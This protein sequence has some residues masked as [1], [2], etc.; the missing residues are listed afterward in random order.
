MKTE[1]LFLSQHGVRTSFVVYKDLLV[2]ILFLFLIFGHNH[3]HDQHRLLIREKL[4]LN[5]DHHLIWRVTLD[6]P[7]IYQRSYDSRH[8]SDEKVLRMKFTVL[9]EKNWCNHYNLQAARKTLTLY[10]FSTVEGYFNLN[11]Q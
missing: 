1:G 8:T 4:Q 5:T 11:V 3:F 10:L 7:T 2:P 9:V 6:H